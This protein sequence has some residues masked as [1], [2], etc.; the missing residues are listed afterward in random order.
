VVTSANPYENVHQS[1]NGLLFF[2]A[3]TVRNNHV[4]AKLIE[5]EEKLKA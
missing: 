2:L 1:T 4:S 5:N 3:Y